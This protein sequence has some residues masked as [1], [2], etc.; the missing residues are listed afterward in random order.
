M[1]INPNELVLDRVRSLSFSDLTDGSVLLRLTS[2]EG[3]SLET[4]STTEEVVDAIGSLV[5]TLYRSK[6]AKFSGSN[7]LFSLDLA[8]AQFGSAKEVAATGN[9]ITIP[10]NEIKTITNG[11]V[12][13]THVPVGT[14]SAEI[15]YIYALNT[16]GSIGNKYTVAAT[17]SAKDFTV[18]AASK[19]ITVPTG[20][21]GD[22]YVEYNYTSESAVKVTNNVEDFPV[23]GRLV[24]DVIFR[25]KCNSNIVYAGKI[26]AAKSKLNPATVTLGMTST[27]KHPFEFTMLKDTCN[28]SGELFSII[29]A[30][31]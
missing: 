23:D 21:T 29:V 10:A 31:D 6:R 18:D 14:P 27:G 15:K 4:T 9:A 22:I 16:D 12:V 7:S 26:I 28:D 24:A 13:L 20:L 11:T 30:E 25:N 17:A 5:T 3:S 19:T 1:A 2:I 8:A